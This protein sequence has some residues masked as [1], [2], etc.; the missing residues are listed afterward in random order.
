MKY[1]LLFLL[2]GIATSQACLNCA[3]Q[4]TA[5]G[6]CSGCDNGFLLDNSGTCGLY[7]PIEDCKIYDTITRGCSQCFPG[8]IL[9]YGICQQLI[10]NCNYSQTNNTD[11]CSACNASYVLV[12]DINCYSSNISNCPMGSLPRI[13]PISGQQY[14]QQFQIQNCAIPSQDISYCKVCLGGFQNINGVCNNITNQVSCPNNACKCQYYYYGNI[15]YQFSIQGCLE[16]SDNL[17]C[18]LCNNTLV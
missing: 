8:S 13:L 9:Q 16:A 3:G 12:N 11:I 18:D 1:L 7:T 10:N 17:Y 5:A 6:L 14:C 4:C 15:C 2:I